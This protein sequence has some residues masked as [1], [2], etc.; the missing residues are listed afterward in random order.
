MWYPL[1]RQAMDF[2]A[3]VFRLVFGL[4]LAKCLIGAS[5]CYGLYIL[6]PGVQFSWSIVSV[7]LVLSPDFSDSLKLAFDRI[8]ANLIGASL[9]LVA[10]LV[11]PP[12]L[13]SLG[14]SILGTIL[15]CAFFRLG[16]VTRTALAAVVIVLIQEK[17]RNNWNLGLQ[18]MAAVVIGS[19][20]GLV[21]SVVFRNLLAR[22]TSGE[23]KDSSE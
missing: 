17:E 12:D 16:N 20:V 1:K 13:L 3:Q 7:L 9:G 8:K 22:P 15:V 18:R 4:Y 19:L 2:R 11:R 5:V 14:A 10:Y 21:L 6:F 23:G